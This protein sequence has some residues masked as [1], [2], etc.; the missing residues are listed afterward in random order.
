M[1]RRSDVRA[2]LRSL[3]T[4]SPRPENVPPLTSAGRYAGG[5]EGGHGFDCALFW[6]SNPRGTVLKDMQE[7]LAA[8]GIDAELHEIAQ[9]LFDTLTSK[10]NLCRGL[11]AGYLLED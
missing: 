10:P 3:L 1:E 7:E 6:V 11:L 8:Y 5:P 9:A 2:A 4:P